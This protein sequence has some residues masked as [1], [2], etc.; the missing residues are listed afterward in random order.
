MVG[1][2]SGPTDLYL[3]WLVLMLTREYYDV[4]CPVPRCSA[5]GRYHRLPGPRSRRGTVGVPAR[6]RERAGPGEDWWLAT[7]GLACRARQ[8]L[9]QSRI[10]ATVTD[11]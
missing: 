6:Q 9:R 4:R 3:F 8:R 7:F 11:R 5:W 1:S 10:G 2:A